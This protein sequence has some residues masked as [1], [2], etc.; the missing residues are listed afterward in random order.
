MS[1]CATAMVWRWHVAAFPGQSTANVIGGLMIAPPRQIAV[2]TC[3]KTPSCPLSDAPGET[4][5]AVVI[6]AAYCTT[7]KTPTRRSVGDAM[8]CRP[9]CQQLVGAR[10]HSRTGTSFPWRSLHFQT[11][12]RSRIVRR[13]TP[14]RR[15]RRFS[16]KPASA[17]FKANHKPASQAK[18]CP[19][20]L[21]LRSEWDGSPS[22]TREFQVSRFGSRE[23]GLTFR[24]K[25][26]R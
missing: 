14:D 23:S 7:M 2:Q 4:K 21:R 6:A 1:I 3:E 16:S 10:A 17:S 5:R 20:S 26:R 19:V 9:C 24:S 18:Q 13:A 11:P 25:Q 12:R 15:R 22:F 8:P